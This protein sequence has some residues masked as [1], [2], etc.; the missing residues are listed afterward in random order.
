[1]FNSIFLKLSENERNAIENDKLEYS[2][3][4]T[5]CCNKI[6]NIIRNKNP[7][8]ENQIE[9]V[10]LLLEKTYYIKQIRE[11]NKRYSKILNNNFFTKSYSEQFKKLPGLNQKY[12][13]ANRYLSNVD[14]IE[15]SVL[16]E[17]KLIICH[18]TYNFPDMSKAK[19][20]H[21]FLYKIKGNNKQICDG[22]FF[23]DINSNVNK[24]SLKNSKLHIFSVEKTYWK[25]L[26]HN[27]KYYIQKYNILDL[28]DEIFKD[29]LKTLNLLKED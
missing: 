1:M 19:I 18:L 20:E 25:S 29:K 15:N 24:L 22:L 6:K 23:K 8:I 13:I 16:P 28:L 3:K 4:L 17:D 12:Q 21:T 26:T 5:D 14:F 11:L 7:F 10:Q 27:G 9:Y 2:K